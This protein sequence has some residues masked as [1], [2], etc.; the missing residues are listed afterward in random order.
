[1]VDVLQANAPPN[2]YMDPVHPN[3]VGHEMIADQ[4]YNVIRGLPVYTAACQQS[5]VNVANSASP[6]ASP[7][8]TTAH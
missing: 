4:L 2:F 8:G 5:A 6:A 7:N 1:M 3:P